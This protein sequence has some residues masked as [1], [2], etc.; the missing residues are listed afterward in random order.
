[1]LH[2]H[3]VQDTSETHVVSAYPTVIPTTFRDVFGQLVHQLLSDGKICRRPLCFMVKSCVI[4]CFRLRFSH[5]N[6]SID[7][8]GTVSISKS[9]VFFFKVTRAIPGLPWTQD[10]VNVLRGVDQF[11]WKHLKTK[12]FSRRQELWVWSIWQRLT[13]F[14]CVW[15][16]F[17]IIV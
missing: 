16:C 14:D 6:Q 11:I 12:D 10:W 1:M 13:A 7:Q 9:E 4:H 15:H 8:L 2:S 5:L 3:L 17:V